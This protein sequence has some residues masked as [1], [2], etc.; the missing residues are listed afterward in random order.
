MNYLNR[1][2]ELLAEGSMSIERLHRKKSKEN[3]GHENPVTKA[4]I[5]YKFKTS[6]NRF[7]VSKAKGTIPGGTIGG[8]KS[9]PDKGRDRSRVHKKRAN[10]IKK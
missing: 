4:K 1:I 3:R 2:T 8:N 9:V 6:G 5:D 10:R 7:D